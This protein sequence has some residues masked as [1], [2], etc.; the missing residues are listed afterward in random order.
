VERRPL[1]KQEEAILDFESRTWRLRGSKE[2]A[3]RDEM[4][5][6]SVAYYL[7]LTRLLDRPEAEEYAPMMVH[8]LRRIRDRAIDRKRVRR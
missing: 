1:T 4:G 8:R 3:I 6:G 7:A 5:M 2:N